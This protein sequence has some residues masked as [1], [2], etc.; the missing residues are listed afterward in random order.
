MIEPWIGE[1]VQYRLTHDDA[2]SANKHRVD[3]ADHYKEHA[4]ASNGVQVHIGNQHNAGDVVPLM[5]VKTWPNEYPDGASVC[6]DYVPS[7]IVAH[8]DVPLS[9]FGVNGQAFL[10]GNDTL[11]VTSAP[12]GNF[13]GAWMH[14]HPS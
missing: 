3:S 1:I 4:D 14:I 10:D 6:I 9:G 5:V 11:W 12:E 13:N 2:Q 7:A 8:W